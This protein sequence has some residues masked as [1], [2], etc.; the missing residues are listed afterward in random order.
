MSKPQMKE[1]CFRMEANIA[2]KMLK[3]SQM[4]YLVI[5]ACLFK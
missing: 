4:F 2:R 3:G 5:A 1:I